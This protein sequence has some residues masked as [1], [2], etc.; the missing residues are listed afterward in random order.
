MKEVVSPI[1]DNNLKTHWTTAAK[2]W[3][4]PYWDWALPQLDTQKFGVPGVFNEPTIQITQPD[5]TTLSMPNP[6]YVFQNT[7]KGELTPMGD[8]SMKPYN[9]DFKGQP[10]VNAGYC[11]EIANC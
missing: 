4:L 9:I 7:V 5:K 8:E 1:S 3:R 10:E 11:N 2:T 6:L